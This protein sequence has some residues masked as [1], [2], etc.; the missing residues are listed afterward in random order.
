MRI[1]KYFTPIFFLITSSC[2]NMGEYQEEVYKAPCKVVV[3]VDACGIEDIGHNLP[4]LHQLITTSL[5]DPSLNYVGRIWYKKHSG[6]DY[7]ITDMPLES[8][9]S[10]YHTF[11]CAGESVT[12]SDSGVYNT[13]TDRDIIWISYCPAPGVEV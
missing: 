7:I 6:Q 12:I 9:G 2:I 1:L 8:G 5:T 13:L 11:N 4:W 3:E 10:G